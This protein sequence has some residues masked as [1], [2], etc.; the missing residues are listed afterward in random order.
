MS[1]QDLKVTDQV[2]DTV[3]AGMAKAATLGKETKESALQKLHVIN[4]SEIEVGHLAE[5]RGQ[6]PSAQQYGRT[7]VEDHQNMDASLTEFSKAQNIEPAPIQLPEE[8]KSLQEKLKSIKGELESCS[9]DEFDKRFADLMVKAH[10]EAI[11]L[12]KGARSSL[13]DPQIEAFLDTV[14]SK[15]ESHL[16]E[17]KNLQ[18]TI[19]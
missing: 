8:V 10:L 9:D 17:S 12:G 3:Y 19:H 4:K 15:L 1:D 13:E 2:K 6:S 7:L 5:K 14:I 18:A 11:E 16:Q